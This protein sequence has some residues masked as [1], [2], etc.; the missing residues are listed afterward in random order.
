MFRPVVRQLSKISFLCHP[1][2]C[3][4]CIDMNEDGLGVGRI[5]STHVKVEYDSK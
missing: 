2:A 3:Y 1:Q 5:C 4:V